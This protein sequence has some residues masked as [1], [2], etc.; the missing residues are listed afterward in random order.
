MRSYT[1]SSK[2]APLCSRRDC[3]FNTCVCLKVD[4]VL[5]LS[6]L[7]VPHYFYLAFWGIR[8]TW[9]RIDEN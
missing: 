1:E 4:N 9:A 2:T 3:A 5:P 8:A 6:L 7:V